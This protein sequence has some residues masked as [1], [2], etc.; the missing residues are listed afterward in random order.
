MARR[1]TLCLSMIVKN[2]AAV[3][4]RCL[5]SVRP[6]IDHWV[7]VDTGSSDGTQDII[8]DALRDVAGE[9]HER[10][11]RD[12]AHN[13]T[14]A[15]D[16]ARPRADYSLIIDADDELEIPKNYRLPRLTA[17]AYVLDIDHPPVRYQRIQIVS[18]ARPWRYVGV[19]HEFLTCAGAGPSGRLPP[20]Y[21]MHFDGA[22]RRDPQTYARDA[23]VLENALATETDPLLR[24]RYTFY[25]AQS[26]RDSGDPG[27]AL[28]LYRERAG[29]GQWQEEVYVSLLEAARLMES[30]GHPDEEVIHAYGQAARAAPRR[31]EAL[32]G[33]AR[34]CRERKRYEDGFRHAA[35][36][37]A[38]A[39]PKSGLFVEPWIYDWGL[40]DEYAIHAYW[41]G[42]YRESLEACLE[43][44]TQQKLP[45]EHRD[46]V[47]TNAGYAKH[48]LTG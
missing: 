17:D 1:T 6:L 25:L 15:L 22:R 40:L 28:R 26:C 42:H 16:L 9:L 3:I 11:W 44:L 36:G 29:L 2:E 24:A 33:A 38:I 8:R 27:K 13:R 10:P 31:A 39:M 19:L 20:V 45:A 32:H 35:A 46:R 4:R 7:I 37:I 47:M 5:D 43:L 23:A 30:L 21:R 41:T 34:L 18:N 14:E 48:K 12:F